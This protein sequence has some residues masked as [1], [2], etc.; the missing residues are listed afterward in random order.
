M[1][2]NPQLTELSNLSKDLMAKIKE[3]ET[4][5]SY[6]AVFSAAHRLGVI[7]DGPTWVEDVQK[8]ED[9]FYYTKL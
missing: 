9:F 3:I 8:L 4:H 6:E 1:N 7:Y 2:T 5:P